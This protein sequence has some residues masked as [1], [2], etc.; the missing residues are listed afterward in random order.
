LPITRDSFIYQQDI[1]YN[2]VYTYTS[3][4]CLANLAAST[5]EGADEVTEGVAENAERRKSRTDQ[6]TH[7]V[8]RKKQQQPFQFLHLSTR[9]LNYKQLQIKVYDI[10]WSKLSHG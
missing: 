4:N 3:V 9:V 7:S 10:Y 5:A 1:I 6:T 8:S 2:C